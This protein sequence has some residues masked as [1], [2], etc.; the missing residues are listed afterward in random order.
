M[1]PILEVLREWDFFDMPILRHGF[2]PN[3]RDYYLDV[4]VIDPGK[5]ERRFTIVFRACMECRYR[6]VL[7][8]VGEDRSILDDAFADVDRWEAADYP[9]GYVWVDW[10][11]AHPGLQLIDGSERAAEWSLRTRLPM[12]EIEIET[13][14][15]R[16]SLVFHDVVVEQP[17][18]PG[19]VT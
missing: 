13:N 14:V 4:A 19:E 18:A 2:R 11:I 1:A 10:A 8:L 3:N 17:A 7:P 5:E 9:L 12:H 16:L 15:Y 6:C